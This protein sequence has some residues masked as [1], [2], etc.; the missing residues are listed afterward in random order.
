LTLPIYCSAALAFVALVQLF[1]TNLA[2]FLPLTEM[3][4]QMAN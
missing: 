4:K 2:M 1:V 3:M